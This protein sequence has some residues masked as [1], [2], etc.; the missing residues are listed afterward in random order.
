MRQAAETSGPNRAGVRQRT[1]RGQIID[2]ILDRGLQAGDPIP[3]EGELMAL[4]D[5]GRNTLREALKALQAIGVVDVRH[6]YGMYVGAGN[7]DSFVEGLSFRG[8]LSLR[9]DR[10]EARE[11]V[12]VRE[13]LETG[14]ISRTIVLMTPASLEEVTATVERME[15]RAARNERFADL[16][17]QFHRQLF[18]PLENALLAELLTAFWIVYHQ[19]SQ[20]IGEDV[21]DPRDVAASHRSILL[22]VADQDHIGAAAAMQRHFVGIHSRLGRSG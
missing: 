11:L 1:L 2:L 14:L 19:V 20:E 5:V 18:A 9:H 16:D 12:Q 10:H 21:V 15:A 3:T 8:R 22:A 13:A 6:G 17:N 7:L 4:L